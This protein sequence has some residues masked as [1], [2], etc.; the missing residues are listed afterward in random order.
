[1]LPAVQSSFKL[2][3]RISMVAENLSKRLIK[4]RTVN[5]TTS[6]TANLIKQKKLQSNTNFKAHD[7]YNNAY[8]VIISYYC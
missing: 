3:V 5:I 8:I 1:M 6:D 4:A 2:A 7:R